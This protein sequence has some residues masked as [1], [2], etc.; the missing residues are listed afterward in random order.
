MTKIF[1]SNQLKK[2]YKKGYLDNILKK[3]KMN[4]Q[5]FIGAGGDASAF[6]YDNNQIIKICAKKNAYFKLF[7]SAEQF[8]KISQENSNFLLSII[9][10]IYEDERVFI[11]SQ[12]KCSRY[13]NK[14]LNKKTLKE[15]LNIVYLMLKSNI[16]TKLSSHNLGFYNNQLIV[17]DYHA[18]DFI[19]W[20]NKTIFK[21]EWFKILLNQILS[22]YILIYNSNNKEL[23]KL[24][25]NDNFDKHTFNTFF[26]TKSFPESILRLL[27]YICINK[28]DISREQLCKLIKKCKNQI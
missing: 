2:F 26:L 15:F 5:T 25:K 14:L 6:T 13:N 11:Y 7:S 20:D 1:I 3:Y 12:N 18:L 27:K 19:K 22:K 17:F 23:I 24:I 4:E 16:R 10:L 9:D 28:M 21:E 8:K